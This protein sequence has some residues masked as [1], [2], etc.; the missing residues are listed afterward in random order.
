MDQTRGRAA[1]LTQVRFL[2][3]EDAEKQCKQAMQ[4][5]IHYPTYGQNIPVTA[6]VHQ[7]VSF[8]MQTSHFLMSAVTMATY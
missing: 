1:D 2:R 5:H 7:Y 8:Q 6:C 3:K 4:A